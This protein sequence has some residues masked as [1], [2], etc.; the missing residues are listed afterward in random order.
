[1]MMNN[2]LSTAQVNNRD[3]RDKTN[4]DNNKEQHIPYQEVQT[5]QTKVTL[6]F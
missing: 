5:G 3:H 4:L 2:H 6:T 1:M